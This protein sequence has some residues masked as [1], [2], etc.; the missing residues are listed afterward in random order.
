MVHNNYTA[1]VQMDTEIS[2]SVG[3]LKSGIETNMMLDENGL[4]LRQ[5]KNTNDYEALLTSSRLSFVKKDDINNPIASFGVEGAY[6]DR[7]RSNQELSVGSSNAGWFDFII[8]LTGM[9]E[10][11]RSVAN[12]AMPFQITSHPVNTTG[13]QSGILRVS[14]I[15][16]ALTYQWQKSYNGTTWSNISGERSSTYTVTLDSAANAQAYYRCAVTNTANNTSTTKYSNA[17][18]VNCTNA[19]IVAVSN[20]NGTLTASAFGNTSGMA[21]QW[22]SLSGNAWNA[23][24]GATS[25][26]YM[27]SAGTYCC[28]VSRNNAYNT[29]GQIIVTT[30]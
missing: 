21:Y 5:T 11:W 7:L 3:D 27:A 23:I 4:H 6:A 30:N 8:M 16:S 26:T 20:N 1:L 29:S 22:Y 12:Y 18:Q 24:S 25:S 19:P 13:V 2:A 9:A 10:K 17:A 14:A 28:V 15:G